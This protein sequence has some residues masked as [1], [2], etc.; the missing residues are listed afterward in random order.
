MKTLIKTALI[1]LSLTA[2]GLAASATTASARDNG[3]FSIVIGSGGYD[4]RHAGPGRHHRDMRNRVACSPRLAV[5]KARSM[6]FHR[7]RVVDVD[8]RSVKVAGSRRGHRAG[9]IFANRRGCPVVA[10]R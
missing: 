7:A 1:A 10:V 5:Q 2:A 4:G 6:G 9:V 3:G 8:R